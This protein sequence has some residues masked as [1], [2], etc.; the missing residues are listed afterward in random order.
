M[1]DDYNW[2][3]VRQSVKEMFGTNI[4]VRG[5]GVWYKQI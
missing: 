2:D 1:G 4:T 3:P 5:K